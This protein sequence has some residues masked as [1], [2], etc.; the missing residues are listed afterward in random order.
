MTEH[1]SSTCPLK[2]NKLD[3]HKQ[4]ERVLSSFRSNGYFTIHHFISRTEHIRISCSSLQSASHLNSQQQQQQ[5]QLLLQP[6]THWSEHG[7]LQDQQRTGMEGVYYAQKKSDI[8]TPILDKKKSLYFQ[9][10]SV[11]RIY[12]HL[13]AFTVCPSEVILTSYMLPTKELPN[14]VMMQKHNPL[15][16][17]RIIFFYSFYL[18]KNFCKY[19]NLRILQD[20][21]S[22]KTNTRWE[23]D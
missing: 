4:Q 22:Q 23:S 19:D 11:T 3:F 18:T 7:N 20:K 5:Q 17:R 6:L 1:A 15:H 8:N 16:I 12:A 2:E 14:S 13:L 9:N 10:F 21:S